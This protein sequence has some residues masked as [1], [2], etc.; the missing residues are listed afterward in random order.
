VWIAREKD[1]GNIL[2]NKDLNNKICYR[3]SRDFP[4]GKQLQ[5]DGDAN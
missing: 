1:I 3:V 2:L 4:E 5:N